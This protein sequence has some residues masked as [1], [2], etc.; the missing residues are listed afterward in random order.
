MKEGIQVVHDQRAVCSRELI[1][2]SPERRSLRGSQEGPS[3]GA[4]EGI[5]RT[6]STGEAIAHNRH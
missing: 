5:S 2:T 1:K 4:R 6:G 3:L